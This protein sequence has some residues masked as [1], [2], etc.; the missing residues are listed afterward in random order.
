MASK[1][2]YLFKNVGLMAI[3]Q[4]GS[5]ML[6]FLL[7]PLYTSVLSTADY[8]TFDLYSTIIQLLMP[9]L[10]LNIYDAVLR[11]ALDKKENIR[12]VY[13][14]GMGII[15]AG[16]MTLLALVVANLFL[17]FLPIVNQ[18]PWLFFLF[19]LTNI[20]SL[21]LNNFAR[22][23][24]DVPAT[25]ISGAITTLTMIIL[26]I[27]F[28][29]GLRWGL[30]G[31]FAAN[32]IGIGAG[33]LVYAL[34]LR[35]WQYPIIPQKITL[36]RRMVAYSSPLIV[37]SV[38]WWIN[39]A[40]SRYIII[41]ISGIAANG[42]FSA[43]NKIPSIISIVANLF[44]SAWVM[45]SVKEFDPEDKERFFSKTY[46]TFS[47]MIMICCALLITGSYILGNF[48]YRGEFHP[49]WMIAPLMTLGAAFSAVA[50]YLGG[51]FAAAKRTKI[52]AYSTF[53][54]CVANIIL[55]AILT[56]LFGVMGAAAA[57]AISNYV[58]LVIRFVQI[59]GFMRIDLG[60]FREH[61]VYALLIAES[62]TVLGVEENPIW[63]APS[64]ALTLTSVLLYHKE[65]KALVNKLVGG[66]MNR[67]A[68]KHALK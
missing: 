62:F 36:G 16:S 42:L 45:S 35:L 14:V 57:I 40:S 34:R 65:L 5:R 68:G 51:I 28:L 55:C 33:C 12:Q 13:A 58:I 43:A 56:K 47:G 37:N 29:V 59:K 60:L 66:R 61:V 24:D 30:F 19:Y 17:G 31:Y 32:V 38:S 4:F 10:S 6:S 15:L 11:F 27:W 53:A 25:V 52:F 54:G 48:L 9:V 20:L 50:G 63:Y 2:R 67:H 18:Y 8:G 7:V 49:A 41:W 39:S 1:Y 26:N 23:M 3:G 21:F 44:N 64:V 22:G 46:K